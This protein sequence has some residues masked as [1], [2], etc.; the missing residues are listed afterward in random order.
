MP[1]TREQRIG[2]L[3]TQA[4]LKT[5]QDA[6]LGLDREDIEKDTNGVHP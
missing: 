3:R 1:V 5:H 2:F 6:F 4:G